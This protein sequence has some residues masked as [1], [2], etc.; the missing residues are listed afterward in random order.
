MRSVKYHLWQKTSSQSGTR[1]SILEMKIVF[2][3]YPIGVSLT[4][5]AMTEMLPRKVEV[6]LCASARVGLR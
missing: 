1:E 5:V 4:A 2:S 6:E 3:I